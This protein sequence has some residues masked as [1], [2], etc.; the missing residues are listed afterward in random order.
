MRFSS[1]DALFEAPPATQ[2]AEQFEPAR[3]WSPGQSKAPAHRWPGLCRIGHLAS[4][5]ALLL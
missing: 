2:F 5:Y 4:L 1:V 3:D